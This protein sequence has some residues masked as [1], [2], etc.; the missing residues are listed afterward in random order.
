MACECHTPSEWQN[1]NLNPGRLTPQFPPVSSRGHSVTT[2]P[3]RT[4]RPGT[5]RTEFKPQLGRGNI[6]SP[7]LTLLWK[8][9]CH[10]T[11]LVRDTRFYLHWEECQGHRLEGTHC[12]AILIDTMCH[13]SRSGSQ[14]PC[15]TVWHLIMNWNCDLM[16][17]CGQGVERD[18]ETTREKEEKG[19]GGME[20]GGATGEAAEF[21]ASTIT[22]EKFCLSGKA[23]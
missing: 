1:Q 3:A 12:V 8:S 4:A 7:F 5:D 6:V 9:Q 18:R 14:A 2:P 19:G 20:G 16:C 10:F 21:V 22:L 15:P 17:Q 11:C 13:D 23:V